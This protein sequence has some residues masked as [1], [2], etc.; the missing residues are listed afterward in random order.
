M[1]TPDIIMLALLI[2]GLWIEDIM[3]VNKRSENKKK[4]ESHV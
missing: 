4:G 3:F 1:D 2:G